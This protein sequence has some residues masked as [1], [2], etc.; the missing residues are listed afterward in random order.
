MRIDLPDRQYS[1]TFSYNQGGD[2]YM[3]RFSFRLIIHNDWH[4]D[5]SRLRVCA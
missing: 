4:S 1:I 3:L 2:R 5:N